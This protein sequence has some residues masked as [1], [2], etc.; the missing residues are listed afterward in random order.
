GP[1]A[2]AAGGG[3]TGRDGP[4]CDEAAE[5][6]DPGKVDQ[7][8]RTAQARDPPAVALPAVH[9]PVV[10][11]VAPELAVR[12]ERVRRRARDLA[13]LEQLGLRLVICALAS[14]VDRDV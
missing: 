8:E 3:R 6:V 1:P 2:A 10:E 4:V 12:A 13:L 7:L 9:V 5:V 14:D 11:R